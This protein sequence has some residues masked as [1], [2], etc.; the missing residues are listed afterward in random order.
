MESLVDLCHRGGDV[1]N[2]AVGGS[3]PDRHPVALCI[4]YDSLVVVLGGSKLVG[5]LPY[6]KPV[7]VRRACRV[8]KLLQQ[9]IQRFFV[10]QRKR[11]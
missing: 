4:K 10:T 1:E 8:I 6:R 9:P 3:G 11:D 2:N 7:V 5:K